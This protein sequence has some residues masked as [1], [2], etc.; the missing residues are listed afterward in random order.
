M[1]ELSFEFTQCQ[2][3][4][5]NRLDRR[6]L[7]RALGRHPGL[8]SLTTTTE[9]AIDRRPKIVEL[10]VH[11]DRRNGD[12]GPL[13]VFLVFRFEFFLQTFDGVRGHLDSPQQMHGDRPVVEHLLLAAEVLLGDRCRK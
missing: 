7:N 10:R 8:P 2:A 6:Q 9:T 5:R 3:E 1:V 11:L 13:V 4:R 12:V